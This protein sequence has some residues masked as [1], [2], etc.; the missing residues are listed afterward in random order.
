VSPDTRNVANDLKYFP[1]EEI[2]K[3]LAERRRPFATL[4]LNLDKDINVATIVRTHNA[5]CGEEFFW[6]GRRKFYRPGAV[7]TYLYE[8]MTHLQDLEEA[9]AKLG[10]R[11]TWIGVDNR[12]GAVKITDFPWETQKPP[13]L[14]FGHE[15]SGLDFLPGLADYCS[16]VVSIPQT[17]SVR[18]LNV[19]VAAGILMY[20]LC[21]KR[22][23]L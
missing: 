23:W 12:P 19:S 8:N 16:Q 2:K 9:R 6:L 10:D 14:L 18:S 15:N 3:R 17:G 20:D 13:L 1:I 5:F 22:G 4:C 21:V 11:Y 7:G